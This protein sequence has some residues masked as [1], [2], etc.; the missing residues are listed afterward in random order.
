MLLLAHRLRRPIQWTPMRWLSN[1]VYDGLDALLSLVATAG[2]GLAILAW[3]VVAGG[4]LGLAFHLRRQTTRGHWPATLFVGG[5]A[6]IAH[7]A[8]IGITLAM[9]SDLA[10]EANPIWLAVVERCGLPFAIGYGLTGK[11]LV[12]LLCGE[13]FLLYR[14][15][16]ARFFP[17]QATTLREFWRGFG[18]SAPRWFGMHPGP[19]VNFFGYMFALTAPFS[20]YIVLL[21]SLVDSPA[22]PS[23]PPMPLVLLIYLVGLAASYPLVN[24]RAFRR[25]LDRSR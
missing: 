4:A 3:L 20:F 16:R 23:L 6:L 25:Q 15:G 8:D 18:S 10:L 7:L 11:L 24:F 13:F 17:G 1:L 12:A 21:N 9:S 5:I 22:Y 19:L 2:V 14:C